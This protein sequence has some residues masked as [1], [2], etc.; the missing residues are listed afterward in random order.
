MTQNIY[1][2]KWNHL[3]VVHCR[4]LMSRQKL[5][6]NRLPCFRLDRVSHC[7]N[8]RTKLNCAIFYG[9][10][11]VARKS[12]KS[13]LQLKPQLLNSNH[14]TCRHC[15]VKYVPRA[16]HDP[17]EDSVKHEKESVG[18]KTKVLLMWWAE[19]YLPIPSSVL[20]DQQ[21]SFFLL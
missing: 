18:V 2:M 21:N 7:S 17:L 20:Y 12:G 1:K 16:K 3:L 19:S 6:L 9:K 5:L 14:N 10:R 15:I 13:W 4:F 8:I 11:N